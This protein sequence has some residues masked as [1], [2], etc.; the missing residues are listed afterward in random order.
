MINVFV[1]L[2]VETLWCT[3]HEVSWYLESG[4]VTFK[5]LLLKEFEVSWHKTILKIY[6]PHVIWWHW[7]KWRCYLASNKMQI[8][9]GKWKKKCNVTHF[10]EKWF[11]GNGQYC[12]FMRSISCWG[13]NQ[14]YLKL[15]SSALCLYSSLRHC[16]EMMSEFLSLV[17]TY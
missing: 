8:L 14:T 7:T 3:S 13:L 10:M 4:E 5:G 17:K 11:Q 16:R 9:G 1:C 2:F 15:K 12:R 6:Y